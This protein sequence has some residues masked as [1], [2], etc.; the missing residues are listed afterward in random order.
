LGVAL[1]GRTSIVVSRDPVFAPSGAI[2]ARSLDEALASAAGQEEVFIAGGAVIYALALPLADRMYLTLIDAE[3]EADTFFP[4]Y[5]ESVWTCVSREDHT[6]DEKNKWPYSF[7][8]WERR[9]S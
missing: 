9:R 5:D 4:E 2:V 6:P 8:V 3:F 1:P 7:T